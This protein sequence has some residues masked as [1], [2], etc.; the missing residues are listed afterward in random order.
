LIEIPQ[1]SQIPAVR[2]Y[3]R[4]L[5]RSP[6]QADDLVQ[7]C[8]CRVLQKQHLWE[9]GTN[10]R[11]WLFTILHNQHVNA[12]R[13]AVRRGT[14]VPDDDIEPLLIGAPRQD[15]RLLLRDLHRALG[16]LSVEQREVVLLVGLEG[17]HYDEVAAILGVPVGT[18]R[19]RLSRAREAL[20]RHMGA[21]ARGE[22]PLAAA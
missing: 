15:D 20:R 12:I 2:R 1:A 8:L 18:V 11:S 14:E 3:A 6:D 21:C 4:A 16:V 17:L 10:L 9:P 7:D 5:A 13:S 19:S 22:S